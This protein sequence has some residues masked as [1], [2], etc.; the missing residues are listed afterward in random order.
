MF[1]SKSIDYLGNLGAQL[2]D[3]QGYATLAHELIQNADD[4]S[5]SRMSFDIR[6]DALILDNDGVFSDCKDMEGSECPWSSDGIHNHKCDFHRFRSIGSGDKRLQEGATGAFGI[7]FISVYH[8][9][10]GLN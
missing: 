8:L 2:R 1:L 3:L 7:G 6:R 10:T 4:A 5:A 9:R